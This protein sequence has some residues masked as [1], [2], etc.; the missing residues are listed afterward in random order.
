MR[1]VLNHRAWLLQIGGQCKFFPRRVASGIGAGTARAFEDR[2]ALA[3]RI[4]LDSRR[5]F[6]L[7]IPPIERDLSSFHGPG[8][9]D[10]LRINA[11]WQKLHLRRP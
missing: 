7:H 11:A 8:N 9:Y 1:N 3:L 5:R 4:A 6:V 2:G 10:F